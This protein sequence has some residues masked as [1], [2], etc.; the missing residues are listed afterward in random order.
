MWVA[1]EQ[2]LWTLSFSRRNAIQAADADAT[3]DAHLSH[4]QRSNS[5]GL[6]GRES[7]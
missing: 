1:T 2:Q 4:A 5:K 7:R 3:R 6:A